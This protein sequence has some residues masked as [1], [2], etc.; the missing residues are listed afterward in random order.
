MILSG[1]ARRLVS[2]GLIEEEQAYKA[3]QG[4][5]EE[6]I[7]FIAY[8]VRNDLVTA[9]HAANAAAFDFGVPLLDLDHFDIDCIPRDLLNQSLIDKHHALPLFRRGDRLYIAISDPTNINALNVFKFN[10]GINT[11]AILVEENKLTALIEKI[12]G[13]GESLALGNLTDSDLDALNITSGEKPEEDEGTSKED[14]APIVRFVNKVLLD[15]INA[16]VSDIHF[17]PYEKTFRVRYRRDGILYEA[18]KPP[19]NLSHRITA[20]LKVMSQL[21][22]AERRVPQD[23]HFKMSLSKTR[24]IEFRISTC[25]VSNGEKVVLRILDPANAALGIDA[26]G[27]EE[28]QKSLFLTAIEKPQGMILVTGPT[29]SGKTVSLYTAI[30]I[31]NTEERN[32]STVEDPVE[33]NVPGVNQVNVNIK[34]GLTF[35]QALR[36]FLR[37]DPD[38]I[39]VGEVRDLET[40]EIAVKAA[41]TGH[42]V[43]ST[44]HT[45]SAPET[46]TRL[47]NM[48]VPSYNIATSVSLIIAQR[49]AR[50]L[51][52]TCRRKE[53]VPEKTLLGM[54][55]KEDDLNKMTLY[56]ASVEGCENCKNG[57]SGRI[58]I[59]EVLPVTD[60][61]GRVIMKGGNAI[62]ILDAAR[63][64]GMLSLREAGINKIKAGLTS[65][66][67]INRVTKD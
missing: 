60:T 49:L 11:H 53:D 20:R 19:V 16:K 56:G 34:A 55:F 40:A 8:I 61:I 37:Q 50:R 58:G 59:Y 27:Y 29:G 38:V 65:I 18:A 15:A 47:S 48:G 41:Q 66:E 42:L 30:N 6:S 24:Q 43:L 35:S 14:D 33:L 23:G 28:K 2:D 10:T 5:T 51:C 64:E 31:L 46:L 21:D 39:M 63:K 9:Q 3:Q 52:P 13:E 32:I 4:A 26:L 17:E 54:G 1:L 62:D 22:I 45:N 12:S 36:S 7:P 67:E 25:P 57:Y 44:L